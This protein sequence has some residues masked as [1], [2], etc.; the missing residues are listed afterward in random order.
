MSAEI[1]VKLNIAAE[2]LQ[3]LLSSPLVKDKIVPGSQ[4]VQQLQTAYYDTA[5]CKL[6]HSGIAYRVRQNGGK[7]EATIKTEKES[8]GGFSSRNEYNIAL[9]DA[10]PVL[11]GFEKEGFDADLVKI[12]GG[13][14]L[15]KLF[16]VSV[17][18]KLCLLKVTEATTLELAVDCGQISSDFTADICP[19][20]ETELE[21]KTGTKEDLLA[22]VDA[23]AALVPISGEER[24]KYER[25]MKLCGIALKSLKK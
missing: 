8:S 18:R 11:H 17:E 13:E 15:Q 25:G 21:I 23:I 12:T 16:T 6:M 1:E 4:A 22:Y 14:P 9:P 24:S 2:D 3:K 19:I 10:A 20:N 5:S 7:F